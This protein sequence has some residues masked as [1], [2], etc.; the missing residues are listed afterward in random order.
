MNFQILR[1]AQRKSFHASRHVFGEPVLLSL[2]V[3]DAFPQ[4]SDGTAKA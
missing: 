1:L 3:S 4:Y 2:L